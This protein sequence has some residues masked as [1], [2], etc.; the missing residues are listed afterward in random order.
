MYR[1]SWI[2]INLDALKNNLEVVKKHSQKEIICVIKANGY[3]TGDYPIVQT[4]LKEGITFFAVSSL[5]E[6][7]ILRK[8]G[9]Q[10]RIIILGFVDSIHVPLCIE[11]NFI[12]TLTSKKWL[13][14]SLQYDL[15]GLKLHFN[16][17][18]G[19][20]RIGIK[21]ADEAQQCLELCLQNN[22]VPEGIF[23]HFACSDQKDQEMTQYQFNKFEE[24]LN[25]L[26]FSFRYIHTSNSDAIFSFEDHLSNA[27]RLGISMFGISSYRKD[28][29]PV[30]SLFSKLSFI[31]TV[32]KEESISYGATY[33]AQH[34]EII[35]T[36]PI[37]YADGWIRK[38]QNRK[39]WIENKLVPIVGRICM[40][41]CMIL[42]PKPYPLHTPVELFGNHISIEDVA[43]ELDT[44][45]YE[46][47]TLLS[48]RLTR[49]YFSNKKVVYK[50][51]PR[52]NSL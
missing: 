52:L 35:G 3:G 27:V 26:N 38:N 43:K 31:K 30:V 47:L 32:K 16:I 25:H 34:D 37:G 15:S 8:Q 24:I 9:L 41:Q 33:H 51:T 39:V 22:I 14:E 40:D 5:D 44:I 19:M 36:L 12:L 11:K 48:D 6:A 29:K 2:E 13:E 42:L 23:T 46:I 18:T 50:T 21:S 4:A 49:I 10:E 45:P 20:N 1:E 7:L 17:D 28:L